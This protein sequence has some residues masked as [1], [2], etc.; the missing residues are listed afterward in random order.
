MHIF[1][2]ENRKKF[3][4]EWISA[5]L[6]E[7]VEE[8]VFSSFYPMSWLFGIDQH[9]QELAHMFMNNVNYERHVGF[10]LQCAVT[11]WTFSRMINVGDSEKYA[12]E[13]FL[14][15]A[16]AV[17]RCKGHDLPTDL[18]PAKANDPVFISK[19]CATEF[20][21]AIANGDIHDPVLWEALACA[22]RRFPTKSM[23]Q[24]IHDQMMKGIWM[25]HNHIAGNNTLV[26]CG[27]STMM[28]GSLTAAQKQAGMSNQD[29]IIAQM[30]DVNTKRNWHNRRGILPYTCLLYTSP[31]PR[32]RTRSR[33]PSSA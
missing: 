31:S 32:D 8:I 10:V 29:R 18:T 5:E 19:W 1:Y 16:C 24:I 13:L 9:H 4:P 3:S 17:R 22:S 21:T 15:L 6:R 14:E 27:D 30:D 33:M 28:T 20:A 2:D 7:V 25:P 11:N 23:G 26:L 12:R